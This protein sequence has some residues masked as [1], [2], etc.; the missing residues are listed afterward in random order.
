MAFRRMAS[1]KTVADLREQAVTLGIDLPVDDEVM[2]GPN[3]PL[4]QPYDRPSGP[5][6][7]RF[8]ILPM[9]GWDGTEDGRPSDLTR[10]PLAKLRPEWRQADLGRRGRRRQARWPG[11]PQSVDDEPQ[12]A[13]R[14][15]RASRGLGGRPRRK[16]RRLE[17]PAGRPPAHP[18]GAVRPGRTPRA[19]PSRGSPIATRS[20][21]GSSASR[22]M[23]R[24]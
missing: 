21:T 4:A 10:A 15:R 7:N 9:E 8:A 14:H 18:F 19:G 1:N 16:F 6:G 12:H 2:A 24:S 22:T 23:A 13:G 5:I 17:R 3:S 20:S 11:Q